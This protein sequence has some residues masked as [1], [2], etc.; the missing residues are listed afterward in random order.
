MF[1]QAKM[2]QTTYYTI[3]NKPAP[4]SPE[5]QLVAICSTLR[6]AEECYNKIL[7][8]GMGMTYIIL[9]RVTTDH[10]GFIIGRE[11]LASDWVR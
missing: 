8:E 1:V 6:Q 2:L 11:V 4:T 10:I 9:E 5:S 7:D 3:H